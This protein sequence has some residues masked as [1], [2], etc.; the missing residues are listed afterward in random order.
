M[1]VH[2]SIVQPTVFCPSCNGGMQRRTGKFGV[3]YY[4]AKHGT[5][6]EK[7]AK[8]LEQIRAARDTES[9]YIP[10][11][12]SLDH[13]VRMQCLAMGPALSPDDQNLLDWIV[14]GD[15]EDDEEDHWKNMRPW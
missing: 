15:P 5:M 11:T 14:D 3:F 7:G 10:Q 4:C 12:P 8:I 2:Q 13:A 6:S 9:T 1:G